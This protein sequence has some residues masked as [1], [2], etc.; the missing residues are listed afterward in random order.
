MYNKLF[1]KILDSSVWLESDS[2]RI[3]WLTLLASM[4]ETGF[5]AFAAVGNVAG[6]A[7]VTLDAAK[8]ALDILSQPDPDS[9]DPENEGK[10]IERVQGGWIVINAPKYRAIQKRADMQ[11]KTRERVRRFREKKRSGNADVT[12]GNDIETQ[13]NDSVTPSEAKAEAKAKRGSR[14]VKNQKKPSTATV[15]VAPHPEPDASWVPRILQALQPVEV[16][17][18]LAAIQLIAEC[19]KRNPTVGCD[20]IAYWIVFEIAKAL[21]PKSRIASPSGYVLRM[22][23][24]DV[25]GGTYEKIR[26]EKERLRAEAEAEAELERSWDEFQPVALAVEIWGSILSWLKSYPL[27]PQ[28]F[29]TWLKP[30]RGVDLRGDTLYVKVPSPEFLHIGDRFSRQIATAIEKRNL[31]VGRVQPVLRPDQITNAAENGSPQ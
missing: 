16:T 24:R 8:V 22:V 26:A 17:D 20:E 7:R 13:R 14:P 29:E 10:R 28:S 21:R 9:F 2:T 27:P 19:K 11:E 18:D 5:C 4:D 30:T 1:G 25:A 23:P 12:H 6:R 31:P 15:S 3:V